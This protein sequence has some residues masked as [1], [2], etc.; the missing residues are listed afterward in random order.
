M[1]KIE[2]PISKNKSIILLL[3]SIMFVA[4][5]IWFITDPWLFFFLPSW[6]IQLTG[7]ISILFFGICGIGYIKTLFQNKAGLVID[8]TGIFHN[9]GGIKAGYVPW[10]DITGIEKF[11]IGSQSFIKV[12]VH[13]PEEYISRQRNP[14]LRRTAALN[15]KMYDTPVHIPSNL[16]KCNFSE[17]YILLNMEFDKYKDNETKRRI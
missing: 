14:I 16:L 11:R 5:G 10:N 4:I 12:L 15:A 13:N 17:L 2:I 1:E 7:A 3:G 6:I 9:M 8:E